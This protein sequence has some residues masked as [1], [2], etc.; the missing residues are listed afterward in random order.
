[1]LGISFC[2]NFLNTSMYIIW[3]NHW[4]FVSE[5]PNCYIA[6]ANFVVQVVVLHIRYYFVC[7]CRCR[8]SFLDVGVQS[9]TGQVGAFL[10]ILNG[11]KRSL[12]E[13]LKVSKL[14]KV[15]AKN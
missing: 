4:F 8:C 7:R 6:G 14:L 1:V 11:K 15:Q 12:I 3:Q 5:L 2:G 13:F 9:V 10:D